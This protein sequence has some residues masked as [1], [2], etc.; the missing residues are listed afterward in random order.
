MSDE[1]DRAWHGG[2]TL[3]GCS[4]RSTCGAAPESRT[5]GVPRSGTR[6]VPR[7]VPKAYCLYGERAVEGANEAAGPQQPA[8]GRRTGQRRTRVRL[9]RKLTTET[10][11]A[12]TNAGTKPSTRKFRSRRWAM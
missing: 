7:A 3:A 12:P 9:S 10:T 2:E 11:S 5:R 1:S 4:E 6:G 8:D